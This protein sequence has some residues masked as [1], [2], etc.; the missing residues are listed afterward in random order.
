MFFQKACIP[1]KCRGIA[2][3]IDQPVGFCLHHSV[4]YCGIQALPGRIDDDNIRPEPTGDHL[5][6]Q[7]L[8]LSCAEGNVFDPVECGVTLRI[9][10]RG[11]NDFYADRFPATACHRQGD[12]TRAAVDVAK[13]II[14]FRCRE[15]QSGLIQFFCLCRVHLEKGGWRQFKLQVKQ[16]IREKFVSVYM[17]KLL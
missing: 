16:S 8:S 15:I 6:Q 3:Y 2:G 1:G 12:G 9:F 5:R 11:R 4:D 7:F 13:E 10:H 17:M 14:R